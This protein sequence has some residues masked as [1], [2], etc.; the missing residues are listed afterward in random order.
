MAMKF[1][2]FLRRI[3]EYLVIKSLKLEIER[4]GVDY[5]PM[6]WLG[7]KSAARSDGTLSRFAAIE[8]VLTDANIREGVVL[9]VG[10]HTGYFSLALA[11]RGFF[12]YGV[13][14]SNSRVYLSFLASQRLRGAFCP[15]ALKVARN[16]VEWLP[17]SDVTLCL[18]VWHHW[19][20]NYGLDDATAILSSVFRKTRR[21]VFFDAGETE[22]GERYNLPYSPSADAAKY[23]EDYLRSMPN[24]AT[25]RRLG[26]HQAFAPR[27]PDGTRDVV[28]RTLFCAELRD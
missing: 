6:P 12:A 14:S 17:S 24:V 16:N 13:E 28:F 20:R 21:F 15:V 25:V 11:E 5:Q 7:W 26:E 10:S 22:M 1:E 19:V 23:L 4:R 18:S 2:P 3:G 27:S 8:K 9:D